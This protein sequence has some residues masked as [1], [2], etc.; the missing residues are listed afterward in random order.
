MSSTPSR[1]SRRR[2][3]CPWR[4]CSTPPTAPARTGS[5]RARRRA[6]RR[7]TIGS[8]TANSR[9][10]TS[11][12]SRRARPS[13]G[14]RPMTAA[15][16]DE[17][18]LDAE[19]PELLLRRGHDGE[20]EQHRRRQLALRGQPV[21]RPL[22][23]HQQ[24]PV[25]RRPRQA[26]GRR[27]SPAAP[28]GSRRRR[29]SHTTPAPT[30]NV[31][32]M[33]TMPARPVAERRRCRRRRRRSRRAGR[34]RGRGRRHG[35]VDALVGADLLQPVG[36]RSWRTGRRSTTRATATARPMSTN[37]DRGDA[38]GAATVSSPPATAMRRSGGDGAR[39]PGRRTRGRA[40]WP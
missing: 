28:A 26:G 29:T 39:C 1:P 12:T 32:A 14:T 21:Q 38:A 4:R 20:H 10:G 27:R 9:N 16:D 15:S 19:G 5:R 11:M 23:V 13:S 34:R 22:L 24:V 30:A 31:A 35:G 25:R 8:S 17:P 36:V 3:S 18:G 6:A 40:A 33:P 2:R 7:P 37:G